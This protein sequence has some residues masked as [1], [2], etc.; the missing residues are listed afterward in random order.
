MIVPN[1]R[2]IHVKLKNL[3]AVTYLQGVEVEVV[4]HQVG[5]V[6]GVGLVDHLE[7]GAEGGEGELHSLARVVG[8]VGVVGEGEQGLMGLEELTPIQ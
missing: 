8:V 2:G 7:Q 6:E 4:G 3:P 5:V 1:W